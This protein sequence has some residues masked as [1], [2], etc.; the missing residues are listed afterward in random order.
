VQK[1]PDAVA[2]ACNWPVNEVDLFARHSYLVRHKEELL[3]RLHGDPE[4]FDAKLAGWWA[5][6]ACCWIGHGW[7]AGIG[8]WIHDGYTLVDRRKLPHLSNAG[9]GVN[10]L[11][12]CTES[13]IDENL[14][15]CEEQA[16][17]LRTW[18]RRLADRLRHVRVACG[19]WKRVT[20]S[21]VTTR[22]GLT[23]VLLD[24]PYT[25]G[26][27]VYAAGGCGGR[28]ASEVREWC[29]QSGN[30]PLFRIVL[31]GRGEEHDALLSLPGWSKVKGLAGGRGY[32]RTDE[33]RSRQASEFLW[34]SPNCVKPEGATQKQGS[35]TVDE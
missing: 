31:C 22:L 33:A 10:S 23:G 19:D 16:A 35:E 17:A 28:L 4:Y 13:L 25:E 11:V 30:D 18:M 15:A 6:G 9:R 8:P 5:W 14:G 27:E 20:S 7:C 34:L 26:M 2:A 1:N 32:A 12:A 24:P 29:A 21:S 3:N